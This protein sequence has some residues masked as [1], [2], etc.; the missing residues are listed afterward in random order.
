[1]GSYVYLL[2][3]N[4]RDLKFSDFWKYANE[5]LLPLCVILLEITGY[6]ILCGWLAF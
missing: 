5:E 6:F 2:L 1:M 3:T 4:N